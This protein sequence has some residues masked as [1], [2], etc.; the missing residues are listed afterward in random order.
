MNLQQHLYTFVVI[1]LLFSAS[2]GT[3]QAQITDAPSTYDLRFND[4]WISTD[5]STFCI[6]IEIK[7]TSGTPD[8]VIASHTFAFFYNKAALTTPVYT[9]I[10][11]DPNVVCDVLGVFTYNPFLST[12]AGYDELGTTGLWNVTT[13]FDSYAD[14]YECPIIT[15][16]TWEPIGTICFSVVDVTASTNIVWDTGLTIANKKDN[17]PM[18]IEGTFSN[19]DYL[20]SNY[21]CNSDPT[22]HNYD[23]TAPITID[24]CETCVDGLLNG[25]ET[26]IDCG[27]S[28]PNCDACAVT[29]PLCM[30][31]CKTVT[32]TRN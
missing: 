18:H 32:L 26:D 12:N 31:Q 10:N 28:N 19:F 2:L 5:E 8:F 3:L 30:P 25:D 23:A 13:L 4:A 14:G 11:F 16:A 20:L 22:A 29:D 6:N 21:A 1:A 27:G 7:G 17:T 9:P 24:T 15:D